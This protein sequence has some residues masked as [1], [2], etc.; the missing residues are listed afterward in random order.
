MSEP[1]CTKQVTV[2]QPSVQCFIY[3]N[4]MQTIR[5][6]TPFSDQATFVCGPT[7]KYD[8]TEQI[9]YDDITLKTLFYS[10]E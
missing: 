7:I 6:F 10:H 5:I 9:G 1:Q 2:T 8:A 3:I 4:N